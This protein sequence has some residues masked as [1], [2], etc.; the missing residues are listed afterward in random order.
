MVPFFHYVTPPYHPASTVPAQ[1]E[2]TTRPSISRKLLLWLSYGVAGIA[3]FPIIYLIEGATRP[4]YDAWR[5]TISSLSFGP[6]G[7]V[8]QGNFILCGV[9]VLW[10]AFVFRK[11]L[12]GGAC[13]TSY[14]IIR[15]IEG[16][17]LVA[18]GF[19][20][21]DPLHT[22][23]LIVI[24]NAMTIGLFVIARRF[25]KQPGWRGW[26]AFSVACGLLPM[27]LMPFFG[28]AL[29]PHSALAGYAGLFERLATNADT[30]WS[31]VLLAR[32]WTR[33]SIGL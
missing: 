11:L 14:P 30:L 27:A 7:W 8:Q 28:M 32:L 15:S 17:G 22:A 2:R 6:W 23:C 10:T 29:N 26:V 1:A 13:A 20:R 12:T 16:L 3:L 4:G 25:W 18:I 24:V 31:L 19:F 5:Q 9:S 33:R 21:L